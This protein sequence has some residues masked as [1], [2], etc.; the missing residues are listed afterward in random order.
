MIK[1]VTLDLNHTDST[2]VT[3]IKNLYEKEG[4]QVSAI[5]N[6]LNAKNIKKDKEESLWTGTNISF[7][8]K[9]NNFK[10]GG[11]VDISKCKMIG[12]KKELIDSINEFKR[13]KKDSLSASKTDSKGVDFEE[14]TFIAYL[15]DNKPVYYNGAKLIKGT[16]KYFFEE[17]E[18]YDFIKKEKNKDRTELLSELS[19]K[20]PDILWNKQQLA[21]R[22]EEIEKWK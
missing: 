22:L 12:S 13:S 5:A 17:K 8:C 4:L 15:G 7:I 21:R 19:T 10:W 3:V 14:K 11:K 2:H 1:N 9:K 20:F 18:I 6:Y 16:L